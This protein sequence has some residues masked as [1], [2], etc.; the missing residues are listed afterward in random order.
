[1][2]AHSQLYAVASQNFKRVFLETTFFLNGRQII[3][4]TTEPILKNFAG[5]C[6]LICPV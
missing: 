6:L 5:F 3:S 1:M 4:G 2:R